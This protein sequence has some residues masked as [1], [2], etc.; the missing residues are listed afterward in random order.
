M[1]HD[2]IH[3]EDSLSSD[4]AHLPIF[5]SSRY[6]ELKSINFV[7]YW[8]YQVVS[9]Y[10][11]RDELLR[12]VLCCCFLPGISGFSVPNF[13]GRRLVTKL[14]YS[15]WHNYGFLA[16]LPKLPLSRQRPLDHGLAA[17]IISFHQTKIRFEKQQKITNLINLMMFT[18]L[19]QLKY[20]AL[21]EG[22]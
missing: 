13:Q 7:L 9:E 20:T 16:F 12:A 21:H 8:L 11:T 3:G 1:S 2:R 14:Q 17:V 10:K 19:K 4:R 5:T 15:L 6:S 22:G 18:C